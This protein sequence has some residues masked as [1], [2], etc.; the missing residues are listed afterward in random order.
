VFAPNASKL[1][2][3]SKQ[4]YLILAEGRALV[5]E[6][7]LSQNNILVIVFIVV[8]GK[9]LWTGPTQKVFSGWTVSFGLVLASDYFCLWNLRVTSQVL[10]M[11]MAEMIS[12]GIITTYLKA[13]SLPSHQITH[14]LGTILLDYSLPPEEIGTKKK[15][16][17]IV[18]FLGSKQKEQQF[19]FTSEP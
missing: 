11:G 1:C 16:P 9:V 10:K 13:A 8:L 15:I 6:S 2:E 3:A 17:R 5:T 12:K 7:S 4:V 14:Q 18:K 19:Q